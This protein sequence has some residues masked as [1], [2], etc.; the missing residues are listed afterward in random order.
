MGNVT[1]LASINNGPGVPATLTVEQEQIEVRSLTATRPDLRWEYVDQAGHFH[2]YDKDG[3]LPTLETRFEQLP[4]PG[5]CDD[6]GCEGYTVTHYHCAICGEE[7]EP[8]RV[9]DPLT[10]VP[11][12]TSWTVEVEA[13]VTDERVSVRLTTGAPLDP[14]EA[15]GVAA[16]GN[17]RAE[18]GSGGVRVWTTLHGV[19]PLGYRQVG[20]VA[21]A[22]S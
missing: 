8:G 12:R 21:A 6:P 3:K 16:R 1:A 15:F 2:A 13:R 14:F 18:G 22:R 19:T 10:F 11:G 4:C 17:I 20:G 7:V 9:P 5:G